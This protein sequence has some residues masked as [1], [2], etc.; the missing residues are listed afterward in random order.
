MNNLSGAAKKNAV[1][2]LRKSAAWAILAGCGFALVRCEMQTAGSSVTTGNPTEIAVSFTGDGTPTSLTGRVE[3]YGATQIPVPGFRPEPLARFDVD[4]KEFRLN[5]GHFEGIADSLW[6][7]GS[8]DG[9]TLAR[10]NL[11]VTGDN[12]G[13]IV[14]GMAIRLKALEF[15]LET[16]LEKARESKVAKVEAG[17][18]PLVEYR[19]FINLE[20]RPKDRLYFLFI[21]GTNFSAKSDS[22]KFV[23]PSIPGGTHKLSYLSLP[24]E[25]L[26]TA[27]DSATVYGLDHLANPSKV[28]TLEPGLIEF[29][30]PMPDE[31]KKP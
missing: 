24:G 22:G 16:G 7:I 19:A 2:L 4:G 5:P 12:V 1:K 9:D 31:Y 8:K 28:D 15:T 11:V 30:V 6:P 20:S 14:R 13:S 25:S 21:S 10:F 3:I 29:N 17:V 27:E 18:A 26:T 23:F